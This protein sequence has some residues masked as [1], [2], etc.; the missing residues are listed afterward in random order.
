MIDAERGITVGAFQDITP[1][2]QAEAALRQSQ[3][4]LQRVIDGSDQGF[5]D[6]NLRSN[7]VHVSARF[8]TMLG[9]AAGEMDLSPGNWGAYLSERDLALARAS[10]A[11]HIAGDT[12]AHEM[13]LRFRCKDGS[14]RWVLTRGC[15]VE[16][17]ADGQPLTMSGTHTDITE[18]RQ[19]EEALRIAAI[20]FE[21][22]EG[23]FV[24]DAQ[25]V[26][27]RVNQAFT[28]IT[29][30]APQE[31]VGRT[32]H[33]LQSGRHDAA[34]YAAMDQ[35]LAVHGS[36][37]GEVW[38]RRR[39]GELYPEWLT[40]T[41]VKDGHGELQN[42]V[43]TLVDTSGRKASEDQ[44]RNL[45]FFDPL[46]SLPNRR[47][48]RDRLE[49]ALASC[50]RHGHG[51]ALLFIDLDNFKDLNDH[52]GHAVGDHL[53][54]QVA[55]RIAACLRE[56]DTVARF[57]GD[58]FVVIL[59]YLSAE[60]P[61]VATYA[62][63]VGQKILGALQ[64]PYQ[65]DGYAHHNNASMGV[66]LFA[67]PQGSLDAVL[68]Q[69]DIAMYEAK[70]AG[71]NCLRF[72]DPLMQATV[73]ARAVLEAGLRDAL[74]EGQFQLH[75]QAQI[76]G[77]RRLTGAEV[78]LRWQH[79]QRG[80][81]MPVE[82][83]RLAEDSGLIVP[84]GQ[85]VLERACE[86][87]ARWAQQPALAPL[88]LSVNVSARQFRQ[89]DFVPQVL[90]ALQRC[91]A[92]ARRLKLELTESLLVHDLE[93]TIA[94]M[95]ALRQHGIG[96]S[97]D[98]FGTGYSSLSYLKRLPLDQLK[99]DQSFVH[100][101]LSDANDAAI[102][103]MVIALGGS[104]GLE[105]LAEGVETQAQRDFLAAEGCSHYQGYWFSR[106]L[107]LADFEALARQAAADAARALVTP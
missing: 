27:L 67:D 2:V 51:G 14:W 16:R 76:Q 98:D 3:Q 18:R 19:S 83:I 43:A 1:R 99:I 17:D 58:E 22:Q 6:W 31:A 75:Y 55:Q 56:E 45:A 105:V 85:W 24:T 63:A 40:I 8:E 79:P 32:P 73:A 71:R 35:R 91:G 106:P 25:R 61:A 38:N 4:L 26:I 95:V 59:N 64:Q 70:S 50:A 68:K 37:Q 5:W 12:A 89:A 81:V 11:R 86:Q 102:A 90:G 13:E 82:F 39:N 88:T 36:W 65:L 23:I 15:I 72:F 100:D 101:C 52:L 92:Q 33:F 94:K 48:L 41:A 103:R 49:Q 28:D 44:I 77:S 42:Y 7:A 104:L 107:P 69:A 74:R 34:F 10:V 57:G 53:L 66:T 46:T 93:A 62:E 60:L 97:L 80:L 9:Y 96:F 54:Q 47:L 30:Y 21:S 84:M 87:L 20:A 29:G 78:L